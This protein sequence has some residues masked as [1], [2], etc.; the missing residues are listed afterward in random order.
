[1]IQI[2]SIFSKIGWFNHLEKLPLREVVGLADLL[3]QAK[4]QRCLENAK[5][6]CQNAKAKNLSEA[7]LAVQPGGRAGGGWK[8][9]RIPEGIFFTAEKQERNRAL[10]IVEFLKVAMW[11]ISVLRDSCERKKVELVGMTKKDHNPYRSSTNSGLVMH[12]QILRKN[13]TNL[14]LVC[15]IERVSPAFWRLKIPNDDSPKRHKIHPPFAILAH[16][17]VRGW[18][19]G[20]W[21]VTSETQSIWVPWNHSQKVIESLGSH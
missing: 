13:P 18:A 3:E 14:V 4:L 21:K 19:V 12:P 1:M 16:L 9:I 6:W 17:V 2:W 8:V 11:E 10:E 5:A 20:V 7:H 15:K